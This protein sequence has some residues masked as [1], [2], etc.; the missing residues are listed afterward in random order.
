MIRLVSLDVDGTLLNEQSRLTPGV[1]R[2]V[3]VAVRA[4]LH[5]VVATG[6][7]FSSTEAILNELAVPYTL[8]SSSGAQIIIQG[9]VAAALSF[10]PEQAGQIFN[11]ALSHASGLFIDQ[12]QR[13]VWVGNE[14][15]IE[16]YKKVN[17]GA[18]AENLEE[19]LS[20]AP[21]KI[22]VVN[23]RPLLE[24]FRQYW[25]T[26]YP[27]IHLT[28][29]FENVL[30]ITPAGATKG[31]ALQIVCDQLGIDLVEVAAVGD[32]ENDLSMFA[33]CGLSIAMGN[34]SEAVKQAADWVAPSNSQ[35]GVAWTLEKILEMNAGG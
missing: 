13:D 11:L 4:G 29:P 31:N 10:P 3:R 28:F 12:P 2:A 30:D 34:A 16:P 35:D 19:V 26:I 23:E 7:S 5:L 25:S 14:A 32:S 18:P 20:P 33:R 22:S 27:D 21:I 8:I 15:Y 6:R 17:F 9:Q 24:H 1:M